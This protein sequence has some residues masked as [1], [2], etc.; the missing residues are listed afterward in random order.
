MLFLSL[1]Y[2]SCSRLF[3]PFLACCSRLRRP[4]WMRGSRLGRS[5]LVCSCLFVALR[6]CAVLPFVALSSFVGVLFSPLSFSV[7]VLSILAVRRLCW[8]AVLVCS[9]LLC[10]CVS[11]A[12]FLSLVAFPQLLCSSLKLLLRHH[13]TV[14]SRTSLA[15]TAARPYAS[16]IPGVA[17]ATGCERS[18]TAAP[19]A[20]SACAAGTLP[21]PSAW[22]SLMEQARN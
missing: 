2:F 20:A 9:F 14:A 21:Q 18:S 4:S 1:S 19:V 11:P 12:R 13:G 8:L 3:H 10:C 16:T 22:R 5:F 17:G 6:W 15:S 7:G